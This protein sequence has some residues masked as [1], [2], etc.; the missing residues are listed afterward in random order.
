[1]KSFLC[2]A[3]QILQKFPRAYSLL[4]ENDEADAYDCKINDPSLSNASTSSIL[5]Q[6][7]ILKKVKD[8]QVQSF[9]KNFS[10]RSSFADNPTSFLH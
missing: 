1:M 7:E 8:P 9:I 6:L 2:V 3:K 4:E 5:P 10:T